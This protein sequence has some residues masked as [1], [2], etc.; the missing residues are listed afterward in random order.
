MSGEALLRILANTL[1]VRLSRARAELRNASTLHGCDAELEEVEPMSARNRDADA[2]EPRDTNVG[3]GSVGR[4]GDA[5][6]SEVAPRW[7][8][9]DHYENNRRWTRALLRRDVDAAS[10]TQNRPAH[11]RAPGRRLSRS[12]GV[13]RFVRGYAAKCRRDC[14]SCR[15]PAGYRLLQWP[16]RNAVPV[17]AG[18]SSISSVWN[19]VTNRSQLQVTRAGP[20]KWTTPSL[21]LVW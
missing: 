13:T 1:F 10:A 17:T 20:A 9:I 4:N 6:I 15:R 2:E 7:L 8:A 16:G 5:T 19:A 14:E 21:V 18:V 3:S 11:S 12:G